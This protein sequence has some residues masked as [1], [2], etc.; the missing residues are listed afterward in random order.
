MSDIIFER[1]VIINQRVKWDIHYH[2]TYELY[3]L[4]DGKVKYF[5]DDKFFYLDSGDLIIIPKKI[6][7]STDSENCLH[8]ER[9]L[10]SFSD[11]IFSPKVAECLNSLCKDGLICIKPEKLP[12][13]EDMLYK[14][15]HEYSSN[16]P[17]IKDFLSVRGEHP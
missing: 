2:E 3:Y 7:H 10:L 11:D 14:I 17:F 8:N 1:K 5:V 6:L 9:L 16:N 4:V 12:I 13:I 15:S